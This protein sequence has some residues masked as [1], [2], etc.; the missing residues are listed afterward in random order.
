METFKKIWDD[1]CFE[2]YSFYILIVIELL[3]SFTFLGYIRIP[4][5]S[6]TIAYLPILIAGCIFG[7]LQSVIVSLVFGIASMFK[8]SA[9][10]VLSADAVF[11]PFLSGSAV[12]SFVL[13]IGT[14][15][16]FGLAVGMAFRFARKRKYGRI[17]IGVVS[18]ISPKIHSLLVYTA[19]GWLFPELG[20]DYR[21]TFHWN[22]N[23]MVFAIICVLSVE[24]LG[25]IYRS[26]TV[27]NV[28]MCINE[29]VNNPYASAKMSFCFIMFALFMLSMSVSAA[30]YFSKRES[31]ML[32][33]HHVKVSEVIY[34]DL[35]LLQIQFL[36]AMLALDVLTVI[37]LFCLY[38]Y[39]SYKEYKGEIDDLTGVMRRRMFL[40]HCDKAQKENGSGLDR[41]GWFLF[42]D[43]DYFKEINDTFGH[44]V[45]D[46]VLKEIAQKLQCVF[47]EHGKVGRIGG[48]EFAVLIDAPMPKQELGQ[49]LERF[50][51]DV[52]EAIPDQKISCSIGA[53][54]F[55]F[56]QNVK[57]LLKETDRMLYKAKE[58]GRACFVIKTKQE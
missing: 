13:S 57:Y 54:E 31:Y 24:L 23:D 53:Y 56:P 17:W 52:S 14:S 38:K 15:V 43:A 27:R 42:V 12:N 28:R 49:R 18:A 35:L 10:Y 16:L 36:I 30:V 32:Q 39:M 9:A 25:V 4:P 29:S 46:T 44:S 55:T 11:S 26:D 41:T 19:M 50:L 40:Y 58:R 51:K 33:Q 1:S 37:L 48:D 8:A 5:I 21:S 45:G 3:M 47:G 2:R 22:L 7:P 20:Y 34:T 6:I